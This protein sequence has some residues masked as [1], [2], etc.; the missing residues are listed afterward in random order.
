MFHYCPSFMPNL[1]HC[2]ALMKRPRFYA[3]EI[4][5]QELSGI[6]VDLMGFASIVSCL[7]RSIER[8]RSFLA[9]EIVRWAHVR[10]TQRVTVRSSAR[11]TLEVMDKRQRMRHYYYR[12]RCAL[13][14]H[15]HRVLWFISRFVF[16][17][18]SSL[19]TRTIQMTSNN[20][21]DCVSLDNLPS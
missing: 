14:Y 3:R 15:Y 8:R 9:S 20:C 5:L 21:R 11:E 4:P 7:S 6:S 1:R 18:Q 19:S 2:A 12:L 13:R 17:L 16:L 10:C